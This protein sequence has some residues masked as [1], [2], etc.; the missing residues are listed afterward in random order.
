M[1]IR[2]ILKLKAGGFNVPVYILNPYLKYKGEIC[3]T[4]KE[5]VL[6]RGS[7]VVLLAETKKGPKQFRSLSIQEASLITSTFEK[8]GYETMILEQPECEFSGIACWDS[9]VHEGWLTVDEGRGASFHKFAFVEDLPEVKWRSVGRL[10]QKVQ[11]YL[12]ISGIE[13]DYIWST[14]FV[15]VNQ[16]KL[17]V[18]D[19]RFLPF[20]Y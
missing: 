5:Y 4:L 19:Y 8:E 15:G 12:D 3:M 16:L 10:V 2:H 11:G 7:R 6:P 20:S 17:I 1:Q 18:C 13:L 9:A 14:T